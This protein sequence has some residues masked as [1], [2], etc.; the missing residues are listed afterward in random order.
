MNFLDKYSL[1]RY[2]YFNYLNASVA[3]FIFYYK[4]K[5]SIFIA[6]ALDP[7]QMA[8]I[9]SEGTKKGGKQIALLEDYSNLTEM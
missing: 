2:E 4:Q 9:N 8:S 5:M 3:K 1:R 7:A 6:F